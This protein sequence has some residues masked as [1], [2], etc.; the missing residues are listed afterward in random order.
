ME[1]SIN[2]PPPVTLK[3]V[4]LLI[5]LGTEILMASPARRQSANTIE[6]KFF[7]IFF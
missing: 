5:L 1:L 3:V 2:A 6:R 4:C 7:L